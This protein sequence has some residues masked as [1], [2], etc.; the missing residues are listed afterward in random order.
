MN[1][2][3]ENKLK[4]AITIYPQKWDKVNYLFGGDVGI[5]LALNGDIYLRT[6]KNNS[7][8]SI[9]DKDVESIDLY[10]F[11][12]GHY[13]DDFERTMGRYNKCDTCS[14][15]LVGLSSDLLDSTYEIVKYN[16]HNYLLPQLEILFLDSF[17][18]G[19]KEM[20]EELMKNYDLNI[21]TILSY[22][23]E[24]YMEPILN[25][26]NSVKKDYIL[27]ML[28][29]YHI[30]KRIAVHELT[31]NSFSP[32]MVNEKLN[33]TLKKIVNS[34]TGVHGIPSKFFIY[35]ITLEEDLSISL[36]DRNKIEDKIID[37]RR[38][39]ISSFDDDV[40]EINTMYD[41]YLENSK[42]L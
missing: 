37:Y 1:T 4:R 36:S 30:T 23:S 6:K 26:C 22:Y 24:N 13:S 15:N 8:Q 7:S 40:T 25:K 35:P 16:K 21:R 34:K 2:I 31:T 28:E 17:L 42:V 18:N 20:A 10:S 19:N 33:E 11:K 29:I 14:K 27:V 32:E 39:Q 5:S 9:K 41:K 38:Q 3:L 12:H